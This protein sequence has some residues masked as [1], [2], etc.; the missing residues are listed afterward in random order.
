MTLW[1]RIEMTLCWTDWRLPATDKTLDLSAVAGSN[2]KS[3]TFWRRLCLCIRSTQRSNYYPGSRRLQNRFF[4]S[5]HIQMLTVFRSEKLVLVAFWTFEELKWCLGSVLIHFEP[6]NALKSLLDFSKCRFSKRLEQFVAFIAFPI[7]R[8]KQID[9]FWDG[10]KAQ[11]GRHLYPKNIGTLPNTPISLSAIRCVSLD[12]LWL[13]YRS[14]S[15]LFP[16]KIRK[17][18]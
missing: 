14:T 15:L 7:P 4:G 11:P 17:P 9:T 8:E 16:M 18:S 5:N 6:P 12:Q 1:T 13:K 10:Q 2:W 3:W